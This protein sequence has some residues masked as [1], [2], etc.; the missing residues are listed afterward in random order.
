MMKRGINLEIHREFDRDI[1]NGNVSFI[2]WDCVFH[3]E[4]FVAVSCRVTGSATG[5]C[6]CR[7]LCT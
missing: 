2:A 5:S 3:P 4:L 6:Y 1:A 7:G